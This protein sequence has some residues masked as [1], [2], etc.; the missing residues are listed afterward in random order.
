M[1][2]LRQALLFIFLMFTLL[3][4]SC[5]IGSV[6]QVHPMECIK[7]FQEFAYSGPEL[8]PKTDIVLPS[9]PWE[10]EAAAR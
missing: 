7:S 6:T 1:N 3:I 5:A 2:K 9:S 10:I 4:S 8:N